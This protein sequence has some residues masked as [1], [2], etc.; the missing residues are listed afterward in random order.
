VGRSRGLEETDAARE[1][2]GIRPAFSLAVLISIRASIFWQENEVKARVSAANRHNTFFIDCSTP[3]VV[4]RRRNTEACLQAIDRP[5]ETMGGD[6]TD[7]LFHRQA[8]S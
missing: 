2:E 1:D 7:R 4:V 8:S 6:Y 5:P 3:E